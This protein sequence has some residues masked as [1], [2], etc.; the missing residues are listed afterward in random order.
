[1]TTADPYRSG[2][3]S[4][5]SMQITTPE[6]VNNYSHHWRYMRARVCWFHATTPLVR[7]CALAPPPCTYLNPSIR[8]QKK[9]SLKECITIRTWRCGLIALCN[10]VLHQWVPSQ[11]LA[12]F[13]FLSLFSSKHRVCLAL[14]EARAAQGSPTV[15]KPSAGIKR[16]WKGVNRQ[17]GVMDA[18]GRP[19]TRFERT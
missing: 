3:V 8:G 13:L 16:V 5:G 14:W 10:S 18:S 11:F 7:R 6:P 15:N 19:L 17:G 9:H 12:C 4:Q 2:A 1:M